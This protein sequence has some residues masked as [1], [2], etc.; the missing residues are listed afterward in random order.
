M[1]CFPCHWLQ[2]KAKHDRSTP[3]LNS[4][5]WNSSPFFLQTWLCSLQKLYFDFVSPQD[6]FPKCIRLVKM[7][8]CHLLTLNFVVRTVSWRCCC[9]VEQLLLT[10]FSCF[11]GI[12]YFS[13]SARQLLRRAHGCWSLG[14]GLRSHNI[15]KAFKF[16][17]LDLYQRWLCQAK[18]LS[19]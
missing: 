7:I 15:Y 19:S 11:V 10:A 6:L 5:S 14:Q 9:L 2:H 13:A 16:P 18:A 1:K 4:L 12:S 17:S 8:L 3:V